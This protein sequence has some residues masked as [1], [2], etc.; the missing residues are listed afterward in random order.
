MTVLDEVKLCRY[1]GG[2][3]KLVIAFYFYIINYEQIL[4]LICYGIIIYRDD[5]I[6]IE[7]TSGTTFKI[8]MTGV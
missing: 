4:F 3:Q 7:Y 1:G 6:I 5:K 8:Y 2:Q